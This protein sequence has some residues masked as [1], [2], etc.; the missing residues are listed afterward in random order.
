M[1]V[2]EGSTSCGSEVASFQTASEHTLKP[3]SLKEESPAW[4]SAL[5]I[6]TCLIEHY[7]CF[8][9]LSTCLDWKS[10]EVCLWVSEVIS[11]KD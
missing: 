6:I 8:S 7:D 3:V 4:D 2:E 5:M 9:W 11:R 10:T 1:N